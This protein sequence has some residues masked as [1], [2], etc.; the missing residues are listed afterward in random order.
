M[1]QFQVVPSFAFLTESLFLRLL[2]KFSKIS[3]EKKVE[4]QCAQLLCSVV[5]A[6]LCPNLQFDWLICYCIDWTETEAALAPT[7]VTV[8]RSENVDWF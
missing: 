8:Q 6:V 3:F 5:V 2:P 1:S 4:V 7:E